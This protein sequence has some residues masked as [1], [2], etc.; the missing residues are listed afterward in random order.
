MVDVCLHPKQIALTLS[1]VKINSKT[2]V[3]ECS[4]MLEFVIRN[5]FYRKDNYEKTTK[6]C[7]K[8]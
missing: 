3:G 1:L 7:Q 8:I 4:G 2:T 6:G 5:G